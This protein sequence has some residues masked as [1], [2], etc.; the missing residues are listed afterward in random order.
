MIVIPVRLNLRERRPERPLSLVRGK[1][2]PPPPPN[3]DATPTSAA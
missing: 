2:L 1:D 3:I